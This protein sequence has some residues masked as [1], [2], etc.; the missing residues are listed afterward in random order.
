MLLR[1]AGFLLTLCLLFAAGCATT[2]SGGG[3]ANTVY[4]QVQNNLTGLTGV[5][6]YLVGD[7]GTRRTLGPVESNR[8]AEYTRDLRTGNYTLVASRAGGADIVSEQ[9]RVDQPGTVVHW[10]M[11]ANQISFSRR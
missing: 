8:T 10:S 3:D 11:L 9:F 7:G 4:L 6:V 5:T 2:G 1:R